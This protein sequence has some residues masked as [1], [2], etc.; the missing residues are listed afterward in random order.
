MTRVKKKPPKKPPAG[1]PDGDGAQARVLAW[2]HRII[3][4][5]GA[6]VRSHV[7]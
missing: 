7:N 6:N 4:R 3:V 1:P 5:D 2:A